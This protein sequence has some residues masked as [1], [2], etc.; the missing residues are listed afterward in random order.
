[1]VILP[2]LARSLHHPALA[3]LLGVVLI[4]IGIFGLAS[5]D[6]AQGW[7]IVILAIG[8]VNLLRLLIKTPEAAPAG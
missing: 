7:S 1:M 4:G 2:R 3:G 8:L 6:I 5:G